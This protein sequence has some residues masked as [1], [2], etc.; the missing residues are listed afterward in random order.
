MHDIILSGKEDSRGYGIAEFDK[1]FNSICR[2]H[3]ENGRAL[4]FAFILYDFNNPEVRKVLEDQSYWEALDHISG[5]Y[6]TVF[7]FHLKAEMAGK[8]TS[9]GPRRQPMS[10]RSLTKANAFVEEKFGITL[11]QSRPLVLFFQVDNNKITDRYVFGLK[12]D[13][14]E[15]AF[16]EIKDALATA[17]ESVDR[18]L[19]EYKNNTQEIFQLIRASLLQ[20][21]L[22]QKISVVVRVASEVR[23]LFSR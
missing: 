21:K 6:L 16:H 14:V 3:R 11:P 15:T 13:S 8:T 4:A 19:P 7:S 12:A 22:L 18:V 1:E 2:S 10:D 9:N 20:R 23:D 5:R 17:V